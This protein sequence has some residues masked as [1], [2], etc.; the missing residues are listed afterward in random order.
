[1][2]QHAKWSWLMFIRKYLHFAPINPHFSRCFLPISDFLSLFLRLC[3]SYFLWCL[4]L[5]NGYKVSR[6]VVLLFSVPCLSVILKFPWL[7]PPSQSSKAPQKC[8]PH[9]TLIWGLIEMWEVKGLVDGWEDHCTSERQDINL[10]TDICS[11][12]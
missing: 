11:L 9:D 4:Y 5:L 3:F 6:K 8:A 2:N 12:V 10:Y 1:M 7:S